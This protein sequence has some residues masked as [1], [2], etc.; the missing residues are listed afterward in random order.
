MEIMLNSLRIGDSRR[1]RFM[2]CVN[3]RPGGRSEFG[4]CKLLGL[5]RWGGMALSDGRCLII[6]CC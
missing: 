5:A 4:D 1:V 3:G 2:G 6:C